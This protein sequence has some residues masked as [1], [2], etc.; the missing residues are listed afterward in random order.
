MARQGKTT[1]QSSQLKWKKV[2]KVKKYIVFGTTLRKKYK[3][4][5]KVKKTS[6]IHKKLK[7]NSYHQYM[8]VAMDSNG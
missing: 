6:Y 8:V 2:K 3:L 4:L 5:G 1:R 7:K